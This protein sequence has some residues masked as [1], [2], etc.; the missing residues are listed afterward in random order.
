M[1]IRVLLKNRYAEFIRPYPDELKDIFSYLAPGSFFNPLVRKHIWDGKISFL[2]YDRVPTGLFLEMRDKI[3]A[4]WDVKFKIYDERVWPSFHRHRDES[5]RPFQNKCVRRMRKASNTGGIILV[6]TGA[7]KTYIAGKYFAELKG[8]GV[9]IVDELGLLQQ[10]QD[11]L[12]RVLGERVGYIGNMKFKP[13]RITVA[14]AQTLHLHRFDKKFKPWHKTLQVVIIDELH[15]MMGKRNH[16]IVSNI[17]PKVCI[18]LTATLR[19]NKK[20][21]RMK[22]MAL[23]GPVIYKFPLSKGVEKKYMTPGIA[24]FVEITKPGHSHLQF[25]EDYDKLVAKSGKFNKIIEKII[26]AGV[27]YDKYILQLLKRPKH[28]RVVSKRLRRIPHAVAYGAVRVRD[29]VAAKQQFE[30]KFIRL[31]IAN[32]VFKKG[33]NLK[34]VDMIIDGANMPSQDDAQQKYGRGVRLC[35]NKSGLMYIDIGFKNPDGVNKKS[36]NYNRFAKATKRRR[37]ALKQLG[38]PVFTIPWN[39]S[40]TEVVKYAMRKLKKELSHHNG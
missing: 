9:F 7:G 8:T 21:I 11:E 16:A 5:D 6:A 30:N 25:W 10:A 18:G 2:K 24:V 23:T 31:L 33:T 14:T 22:A 17:K 28:V 37:S 20:P 36:F 3:E 1:K 38:I 4:E 12:S 39:G 35:A 13:E 27:K 34:R 19:L 15:E 40:G 26:K 32:S 29:R